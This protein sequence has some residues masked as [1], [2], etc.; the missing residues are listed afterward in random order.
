MVLCCI[1]YV[2]AAQCTMV[3]NFD[4]NGQV[5][6]SNSQENEFI[7]LL[8]EKEPQI[9]T[10]LEGEREAMFFDIL[11]GSPIEIFNEERSSAIELKINIV[12]DELIASF[13]LSSG[14]RTEIKFKL[15]DRT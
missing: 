15:Y 9:I 6:L 11:P 3:I 12:A 14:L 10:Y 7:N 5:I 4:K 2:A 13:N 1:F 8:N